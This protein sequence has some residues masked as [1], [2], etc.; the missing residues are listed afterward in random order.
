MN[1]IQAM[2]NRVLA[3]SV[4][5]FLL[6]ATGQGIA[7]SPAATTQEVV[8]QKVAAQ[9]KDKSLLDI[10]GDGGMW[11]HPILL[12][13]FAAVAVLGFCAVMLRK[14]RMMPPLLVQELNGMMVGR[15][16]SEAH[17]LCLSQN[18]P[19]AAVM[20][21]ALTKA[22]MEQPMFN[23]QSMEAAAAEALYA[24]E[25]KMGIW[26]NYLNVCAQIAPMLGLL[27]TVVGMIEAFNQLASGKAEPSDLAQG[28][29]VAMITTAGGLL[30]AIPSMAAYFYFKGQLTII[31]TDMQKA[32]SRM[33]D[34]FTGEINQDGTRPPAGY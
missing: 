30:V 8:N 13:S 4:G 9:Q 21:S 22:N 12:T 32:A 3:L 34:L 31:M 25:S 5:I 17:Q 14:S 7:Q 20:G 16:V 26:V 11:M 18:S 15:Q 23:K 1:K 2:R 6:M 27:G 33:L 28:I 29:G 24:E 10:Y 19:L